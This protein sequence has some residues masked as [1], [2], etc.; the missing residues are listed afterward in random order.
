MIFFYVTILCITLY[1]TLNVYE[2][3]R[4]YQ[5]VLLTPTP[6]PIQ[7]DRIPDHLIIRDQNQNQFVYFLT[8]YFNPNE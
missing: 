4:Q 1:F 8:P 3:L 5:P 7:I 6:V 2:K